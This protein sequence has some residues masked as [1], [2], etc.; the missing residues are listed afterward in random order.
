[1][2]SSKD[3]YEREES[4]AT[5]SIVLTPAPRLHSSNQRL[6]VI[7][8]LVIILAAVLFFLPRVNLV[9]DPAR[10][11]D[12]ISQSN[13]RSN[14]VKL[15]QASPLEDAQVLVFRRE[16]Q[17]LLVEIV[18]LKNSLVEQHVSA[19]AAEDFASFESNLANAE[20]QYQLGN[21]EQAKQAY[22][23]VRSQLSA[24]LDSFQPRLDGVLK[25]A[26]AAIADYRAGDAQELFEMALAM[27]A[28]NVRASRG[29]A[30]ATVLPEIQQVVTDAINCRSRK[31]LDCALQRTQQA[32]ALNADFSPARDLHDALTAQLTQQRYQAKMSQ[33]FLAL[34]QR[35][36]D[37]ARNSF[38]D[39]QRILPEQSSTAL[40][41]AQTDA[42]QEQIEVMQLL[43]KA[44][45]QEAE[46]Q[47]DEA[48][49]IY[50]KLLRRDS[51]LVEPAVRLV[52]VKA[53]SQI[54]A[55]YR[56]YLH[57]PMLLTRSHEAIQAEQLL[58]DTA[59]LAAKSVLL[60]EQHQLLTKHL[61]A[62]K[63]PQEIAFSSDGQ[64]EVIVYKVAELGKFSEKILTMKPGK[65]VASGNRQGYRDVRI[66][67]V[68]SGDSI[69][70]P[71]LIACVDLI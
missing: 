60:A 37:S 14:D 33:G 55:K 70:A 64:T 27:E 34:D 53:R 49:K 41:L 29:L 65:Y 4:G 25:E 2:T 11:A 59:S 1:M 20:S 24:L 18:D 52:V 42:A 36:W 17:D 58:G 13:A 16:A 46:E 44:Q 48:Q 69:I 66:E 38:E 5:A 3:Q 21:Y 35:R 67:F 19:W 12:K 68:V 45:G 40:A 9:E 56:R 39:A 31:D 15:E 8:V 47:W 50:E 23:E 22:D 62:M 54:A 51:S 63:T 26:D 57:D 28:T 10:G 43:D 6:Q 61:S 30:L 71:I 7:V 32:L